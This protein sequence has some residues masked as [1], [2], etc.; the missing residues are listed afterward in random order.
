MV[1][2]RI[3]ETRTPA[4]DTHTHTEIIREDPARSRGG[5][6]WVILIVLI[7]AIAIGAFI[8]MRGSDAEIAKD[9]AIAGAAEN[10]GDAA[11]SVGEAADAAAD[12]I[13]E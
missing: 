7:I 12:R 13:S 2:E 3:T 4:G 6:G 1:E 11:Q 10:V 8:M 9:N 5:M